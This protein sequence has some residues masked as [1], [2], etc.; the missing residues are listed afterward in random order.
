MMDNTGKGITSEMKIPWHNR[1]LTRTLCMV[2]ATGLL[3]LLLLGGI[4]IYFIDQD[5]KQKSEATL[6]VSAENL[7]RQIERYFAEQSGNIKAL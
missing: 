5:A 7:A 6:L 3:P 2:L 1:I 4:A